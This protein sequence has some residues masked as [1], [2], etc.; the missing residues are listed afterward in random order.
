[1]RKYKLIKMFDV[2]KLYT[3]NYSTKEISDNGV[4]KIVIDND[5]KLYNDLLD[6]HLAV[7][8]NNNKELYSL[9]LAPNGFGKL[10]IDKSTGLSFDIDKIKQDAN[11]LKGTTNF[12]SPQYQMMKFLNGTSG[13]MG[14]GVFSSLSML[15]AISQGKGLKYVNVDD[16]GRDSFRIAFGDM[17]SNGHLGELKTLDGSNYISKVIEAFQ[18]ASVDNEK[19]QILY[20]LNI[21]K[22]TASVINALAMLGFNEEVISYFI[23]QPIIEEY[24]KMASEKDSSLDKFKES[25]GGNLFEQLA[26]EIKERYKS[27]AGNIDADNSFK[28][29]GV[30]QL[31]EQMMVNVELRDK[32]PQ[33]Y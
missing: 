33:E 7:F 11:G 10:K 18:S 15:N 6:I 16:K 30:A 31:K 21:N 32:V 22:H 5:N 19:E 17:V 12:L 28:D 4:P 24:V 1:M 27:T 23:N 29:A 20:K 13:K 2:D 8:N 25:L 9:I 14:V 3:Y 26:A